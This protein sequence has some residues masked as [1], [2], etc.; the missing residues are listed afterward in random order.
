[1]IGGGRHFKGIA[2]VILWLR[3]SKLAEKPTVCSIVSLRRSRLR[4][5]EFT[6]CMYSLLCKGGTPRRGEW[7]WRRA[8]GGASSRKRRLHVLQRLA[9]QGRATPQGRLLRKWVASPVSDTPD[10]IVW[11]SFR[12]K[13]S[14]SLYITSLDFGRTRQC[15]VVSYDTTFSVAKHTS[16]QE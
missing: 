12:E 10:K 7:C 4:V 6:L 13:P 8:G 2:A 11:T 14:R 5:D 9:Q 3:S 1:M 15:S 16:P